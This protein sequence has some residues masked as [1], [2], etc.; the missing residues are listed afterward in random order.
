[1]PY[2]VYMLLCHDASIYIGITTDLE[3]RFREHTGGGKGAKYTAARHPERYLRAFQVSDRSQAL[4]LEA[5]LKKLSHA[6]RA[7]LAE[8]GRLPE[9]SDAVSAVQLD[10]TGQKPAG[11]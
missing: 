9:N 1:M 11:V 5:R 4:R 6:Q 8:S 3:R 2:Y 10:E 7:A